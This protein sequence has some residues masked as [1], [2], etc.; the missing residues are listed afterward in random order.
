MADNYNKIITTLNSVSSNY[1][2]IPDQDNVIVIDTSNNRIGINT[3]NPEH[4]IDVCGGTIK[5][6]DLI[7]DNVGT[8]PS[9]KRRNQM[10]NV[11]FG[12][13]DVPSTTWTTLKTFNIT[14]RAS[15]HNFFTCKIL[16]GV[17]QTSFVASY[18][19]G[20][21]YQ[22][23]RETG[24][25]YFGY[26]PA[27]FIKINTTGA[28][29]YLKFRMTRLNATGTSI[30]LEYNSPNI[31]SVFGTLQIIYSDANVNVA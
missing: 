29:A 9:I 16:F 19:G 20:E 2:F 30:G 4:A 31:T 28:Q 21:A 26:S 22:L 8:L 27:E 6:K 14:D 7:I 10:I 11:E 17:R 12:G 5:T 13:V 24:T 1:T 23:I 25:A 3:V 15:G 18:G